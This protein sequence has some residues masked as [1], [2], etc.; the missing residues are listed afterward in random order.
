MGSPSRNEG[1]HPAL[2][3]SAKGRQHRL[4][5][6]TAPD[7]P[8][9]NET[10]PVFLVPGDAWESDSPVECVCGDASDAL[11]VDHAELI[12]ELI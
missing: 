6:D 5:A 2:A 12:L 9:P 11:C 8:W 10:F 1:G 7:R 4:M 3:R